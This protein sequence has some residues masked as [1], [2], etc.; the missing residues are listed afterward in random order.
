MPDVPALDGAALATAPFLDAPFGPLDGPA[1]VAIGRSPD[2]ARLLLRGDAGSAG[3]AFGIVLPD[4]P[5][6]TATAGDRTALWLGPDEWLLVAPVGSLDPKTPMGLGAVVDVGHRQVGLLVDG[7]GAEDALATG[8]P[9]DLHDRVFPPGR[10]TRTV[11][12]KAEIILWRTDHR[13]FHIEVA[14]SFADYVL[15]RLTIAARE[16]DETP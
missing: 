14:R 7:A 10:C 4:R 2:M 15:A 9:L 13:R 3:A 12:G 5:G 16:L 1:T 8:C 6:N 11:F